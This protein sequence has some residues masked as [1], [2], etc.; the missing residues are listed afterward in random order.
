MF[1]LIKRVPGQSSE[2]GSLDL[3]L[4]GSIDPDFRFS[5]VHLDSAGDFKRSGAGASSQLI[6]PRKFELPQGSCE[7]LLRE[8]EDR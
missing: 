1:H 3:E 8:S 6:K 5:F 7:E 4:G 2:A